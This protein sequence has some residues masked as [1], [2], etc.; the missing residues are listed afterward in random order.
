MTMFNGKV[1]VRTNF[2]ST[3][4]SNNA[5]VKHATST[6]NCGIG[7]MCLHVFILHKYSFKPCNH[8]IKLYTANVV[9]LHFQV[10]IGGTQVFL[11]FCHD[12]LFIGI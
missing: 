8:I 9:V 10:E 3:L 5:E 2:T 6:L 7:V 4:T 11:L 12:L 1:K